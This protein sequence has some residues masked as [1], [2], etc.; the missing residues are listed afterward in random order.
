MRKYLVAPPG[1]GSAVSP[2][3]LSVAGGEG[4]ELEEGIETG[5]AGGIAF[6]SRAWAEAEAES[7][8]ARIALRPFM[9]S[10]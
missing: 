10:S 5:A 1:D 9:R 4:V 2:P 6:G 3:Y 8:R 7:T